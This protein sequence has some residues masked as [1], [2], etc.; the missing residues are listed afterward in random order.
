MPEH[1][2][3]LT[4]DSR[5]RASVLQ[6]LSAYLDELPL[7][8]AYTVTVDLAD[9]SRRLEQNSLMW[10]WNTESG[11]FYGE[12]PD[13]MHGFNKCKALYPMMLGI[14][15]LRQDALYFRDAVRML[16]D[17]EHAYWLA[18]RTLRTK[19]L[20]VKQFAEYLTA[21]QDYWGREGLNLTTLAD[22]YEGAMGRAA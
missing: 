21:L 6:G 9:E 4:T 20:T 22:E 16:T 3:K 19:S 7:E 5:N 11:K 2:V 8:Q 1:A 18:N 10:C 15:K 17:P 13:Y 12:D 14:P